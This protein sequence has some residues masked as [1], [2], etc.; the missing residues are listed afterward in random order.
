[1]R[2]VTQVQDKG[3]EPEEREPIK[4]TF[5]LPQIAG[6]ALAAATAAAIGSQLGVA[7]T[8]FGAA[9]ASIVG[10]I[11]GTLYSA[12]I[13]RT[14][15]RVTEAIQ[16]GYERVRTGE[17]DGTPLAA[18]GGD[19]ALLPAVEGERTEIL[20]SVFRAPRDE[21]APGTAAG[22]TDVPPPGRRRS[23][24]FWAVAAITVGS[25]FLVALAAITVVELGL[26]RSLSG[27]DGT[28]VSQVVPRSRT[29]STPTPTPTA[30]VTP[31]PTPTTTDPA[32]PTP[33][34]TPTTTPTQTAPPTDAP[35]GAA[36]EVPGAT[37]TP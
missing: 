10:G 26:G 30:T 15:R 9:V 4:V 31:T 17:A 34:P 16:R 37:T 12:G 8:I 14:H 28:T 29:S 25:I 18:D 5:S 24:T 13:D 6:G 23:R 20:D 36:T 35:T 33:T 2:D 27:N 22:A 19:T 11:G 21:T 1:M 32:T 3:H 7:G